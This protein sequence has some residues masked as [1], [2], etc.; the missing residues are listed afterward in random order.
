MNKKL[1]G[2]IFLYVFIGLTYA[3]AANSQDKDA[4]AAN[5]KKSFSTAS[6]VNKTGIDR[7]NVIEAVDYKNVWKEN[8]ADNISADKTKSF[9]RAIAAQESEVIYKVLFEGDLSYYSI[10]TAWTIIDA[11]NDNN[12]WYAEND[13]ANYRYHSENDADDWL[14]S[15]AIPLIKGLSYKLVY[16]IEDDPA[17]PESFKTVISSDASVDGTMQILG[18]FP[19]YGQGLQTYMHEFTVEEDGNYYIGFHAYSKADRNVLT[20]HAVTLYSEIEE[21]DENFRTI[22][23]EDFYTSDDFNEWTVK[24]LNEDSKTWVYKADKKA[25]YCEYNSS[26]AS[27]DWLL[28]TF[29]LLKPGLTYQLSYTVNTDS[30]A[31]ENFKV[32]Y[33]TSYDIED[34]I[35]VADHADYKNATKETFVQTFTVTEEKEYCLAFHAYSPKDR[36]YIYLHDVTLKEEKEQVEVKQLPFIEEFLTEENFDEWTIIAAENATKTWNYYADEQVARYNQTSADADDWM[37]SP[38]FRLEQGVIYE[39]NYT[40]ETST[41]SLY[42]ENLKSVCSSSTNPADA[43]TILTHE[44]YNKGVG[45]FAE[46]FT[47]PV[48]GVYYIGF[49]AYS[50]DRH[51][52]IYIH[53]VMLGEKKL[54]K[55]DGAVPFYESFDSQEDFNDWSLFDVNND[56]KTFAYSPNRKAAYYTYNTNE[57]ADDWMFSPAVRLYPDAAYV[58]KYTAG[59][60][61]STNPESF[62]AV[63]SNTADPML[64]ENAVLVSDHPEVKD[65]REYSINF[66]V[67]EEADYYIGFHVYSPKNRNV[68]YLFEVEL[69]YAGE[70]EA[71]GLVEDL[72]IIPG[73]QGELTTTISFTAPLITVNGSQLNE[74]TS[75]EIYKN[76]EAT[77]VHSIDEVVPGNG[78]SWTDSDP[79][80]GINSYEIVAYNNSGKGAVMSQSSYVGEDIPATVENLT[81]EIKEGM[82]YISWDAP[83]TGQNGGYIDAANLKYFVMSSRAVFPE[84]S[85]TYLYDNSLEDRQY[86]LY[87]YVAAYN[88]TGLGKETV[89]EQMKFG[90]PYSLPFVDSFSN[91]SQQ[92]PPWILETITENPNGTPYV[93]W[94]FTQSIDEWE[95][96]VSPQDDDRGFAYFNS[97]KTRAGASMRFI[98]PMLDMK[99]VTNPYL[100]FWFYH[101]KTNNSRND[102]IKIE[103]SVN[104]NEYEDLANSTIYLAEN[105]NGWTYYEFPLETYAGVDYIHIAFTG[106]SDYGYDICLDNVVV[107][108][109]YQYDL[110]AASIA[111]PSYI[112]IPQKG[113]IIASVINKGFEKAVGADYKVNL[114]KDNVLSASLDGKDLETGNS[115]EF[116]FELN[117]SFKDEGKTMVYYV[118]IEYS[119]DENSKNNTT[120]DIPVL[121]LTQGLPAATNIEAE[122]DGNTVML[123][124]NAPIYNTKDGE[125]IFED[126]ESYEPFIID[127]IGAWTLIDM[128][129]GETY[130][131]GNVFEGDYPNAGA[132][133]AYQIYNP[134]QA[135]TDLGNSL[136]FKAR[137]GEQYI[138]SWGTPDKSVDPLGAAPNNDWL[139]SPELSGEGETVSFYAKSP[140]NDYGPEKFRFLYSFTDMKPESFVPAHPQDYLEVQNIWTEF[141]YTLPVGAKYFAIQ[142]IS[143]DVYALMID[144]ISYQVKE[145][146]LLGYDIYRD[147]EKI[148]TET[149][150]YETYTDEFVAD[151]TYEYVIISKYVQGESSGSA[152]ITV[153]VNEPSGLGTLKDGVE[154]YSLPKSIMIENAGGKN[155]SIFSVDGKKIYQLNATQQERFVLEAGVYLV[156]IADEIVK[157]QVK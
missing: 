140:I 28:S 68:F 24:N 139:I 109:K 42:R 105:N 50:T 131:P 47:V 6:E 123:T 132:P 71:P 58:L 3:I 150:R 62:T 124:W 13:V 89:T 149:V 11:N 46:S 38:A 83:Q 77:P 156:K 108:E 137:S 32:G 136:S 103:I 36:Y 18:D 130:V 143:D 138:V 54:P 5:Y 122:V 90:T 107:E 52:Y 95:M 20:L 97:G 59:S 126:F 147:G 84:V 119:K 86:Y 110:E 1:P 91:A 49:H 79:V 19:E 75:I 102:Y 125:L 65:S 26:M 113:E 44:S 116:K 35:L 146:Q 121:Y 2:F 112:H 12:K 57:D 115:A 87:Y 111:G 21:T 98:T 145:L 39:L 73:A 72:T 34:F 106:V 70:P 104:D 80:H 133:M 30:Y 69:E 43:I 63:I 78:Y 56:S 64:T 14:F 155:V 129:G 61:D 7:L 10:N 117:S 96:S 82:P 66:S 22:F 127:G 88:E 37:F 41:S 152:K 60:M 48:T 25:A 99:N 81:L 154:V 135:N 31:E 45:E 53:D 101:H 74:I 33:S 9:K 29:I 15:R 55:K 4:N 114:Y 92:T 85:T 8:F 134:G 120:A 128:D 16:T 93:A 141:T 118:K 94:A 144:D 27:D 23:Y 17:Y 100:S 67:T 151:G 153:K 142:Y 40:I 148:N 51:N 76:G 157:V